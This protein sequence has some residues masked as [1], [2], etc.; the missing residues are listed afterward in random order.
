MIFRK[1]DSI[2]MPPLGKPISVDRGRQ[3]G[4]GFSRR[5]CLIQR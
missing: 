5:R 3:E 1:S 2:I 4:P